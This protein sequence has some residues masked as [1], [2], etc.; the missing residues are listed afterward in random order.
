M[1]Y[2]HEVDSYCI[3]IKVDHQIAPSY[4]SRKNASNPLLN[5]L[6]DKIAA[7]PGVIKSDNF[8]VNESELIIA[9]GNEVTVKHYLLDRTTATKC[10][11]NIVKKIQRHY[12]LA[13]PKY[14]VFDNLQLV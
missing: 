3:K 8:E 5:G 9:N 1:K 6:L 11:H 7:T 12:G 13:K 4:T 14:T 10:A 2:R